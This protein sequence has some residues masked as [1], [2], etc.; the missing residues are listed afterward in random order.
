LC[1]IGIAGDGGEKRRGRKDAANEHESGAGESLCGCLLVP[2]G[3]LSISE[4]F[5]I[6]V[7]PID[8]LGRHNLTGNDFVE[9]ARRCRH[10]FNW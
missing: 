2:L 3:V 6:D 5:M 7:K 10:V 4:Y 8:G 1:L 9:R